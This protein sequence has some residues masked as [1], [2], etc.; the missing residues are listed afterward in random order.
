MASFTRV[1][2]FTRDD[3]RADFREEL[4]ELSEGNPQVRLSALMP[5]SGM[6]VRES[7]V[8]FRS[9]VH[10][11][12]QPQWVFILSG[13]MEIGLLDGSSR[14]FLAGE[15]FY[16]ADALPPGAEFDP[17]VHGHWSRQL[18]DEPLVTAFVKS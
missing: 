17:S 11:T 14:R 7:P 1:F 9:K 13:E 12:T 18:G 2:L 15:H 6:Q 4:V 10:V 16:A 3:G 8:G 5:A